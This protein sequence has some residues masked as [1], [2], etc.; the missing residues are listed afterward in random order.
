M[1][2]LVLKFLRR[3]NAT[4]VIRTIIDDDRDK[5]RIKNVDF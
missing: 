3:I 1:L 2:K 5:E 4:N